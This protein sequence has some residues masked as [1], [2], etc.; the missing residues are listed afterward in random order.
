M[1]GQADGL[2]LAGEGQVGQEAG[3]PVAQVFCV[4][5][6]MSQCQHLRLQGKGRES[7]PRGHQHGTGTARRGA[8]RHG[9]RRCYRL[10]DR[11]AERPLCIVCAC[12]G[13]AQ[14]R[15]S[16]QYTGLQT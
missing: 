11:A 13:A 4:K 15:V 2:L 16:S 14:R 10:A 9:A 7:Q 6:Q 3:G 5:V 1:Q 12:A 8:A